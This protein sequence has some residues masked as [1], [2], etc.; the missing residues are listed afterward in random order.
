MDIEMGVG[1]ISLDQPE[2][3]GGHQWL[4][5]Q[6][7]KS[8]PVVEIQVNSSAINRSSFYAVRL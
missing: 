6:T 1:G 3:L 5:S 7:G 8:W 2:S 4:N